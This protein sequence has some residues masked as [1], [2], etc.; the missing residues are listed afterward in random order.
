[1]KASCKRIFCGARMLDEVMRNFGFLSLGIWPDIQFL[2]DAL[3]RFH[4]WMR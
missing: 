4:G 2:S 1:M 3:L